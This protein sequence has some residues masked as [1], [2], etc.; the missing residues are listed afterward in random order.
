MK[1]RL[2]SPPA[3]RERLCGCRNQAISAYGWFC[4][5]CGGRIAHGQE[6]SSG[7]LSLRAG[8]FD[9]PSWIEPAGHIWTGSAQSWVKF[10]PDEILFEAQ[11][12]DYAPLI[13]RY[14]MQGRFE[15]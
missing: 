14:K 4:G 7:V 12:T 8:T 1:H 9:D 2:N 10:G 6:P 11:P 5:E 13:E 15:N 3:S